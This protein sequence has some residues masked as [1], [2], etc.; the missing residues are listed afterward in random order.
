MTVHC[1]TSITFSYLAKARVLA[2]SLKQHHPTWRMIVC[3]TDQPPPGFDFSLET[4]PYFD[5]I[6]WAHD[7]PVKPVYSWLF[8]HNVVEVCTAVKGM[9][10]HDLLKRG[11]D[12]VFYLDPDIAVMSPLT[13]MVD[14]LD[15]SSVLLTPHLLK[16]EETTLGIL[17]NEV[18]A[19]IHGIYNLGFVA[20]R[21]DPNGLA[22][23]A[24]WE[25]RLLDFCYDDKA[26]GLF[27]DQ[28]WCDHVP[29]MFDG[30][31]IVRD[32]G[33]NVAS[34]NISG[35]HISIPSSGDIFVNEQH[36]LRFFHF[37]KLGPTGDAMTRRYAKDNVEVYE[38]WAWYKKKVELFTDTRIPSDYWRYARFDN[39]KEITQ[40][41]R[42]LYRTRGDL[43]TAF[44]QPFQTME[45]SFYNWL[46]SEEPTLV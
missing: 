1:F 4:E 26:S 17:D 24:W 18:S 37:T 10:L 12:K 13:P 30:V 23:A 36:H 44:P 43:R 3:I 11:A 41:M 19:L 20:V 32:P 33:Y 2:W 42:V 46:C 14:W 38:I 40:R 16:P 7:L 6:I 9:V 35:R 25:A 34:W 28:K 39:N 5:E 27:V 21:N 22:F 29:A 31:K 45:N 8:K 15:E